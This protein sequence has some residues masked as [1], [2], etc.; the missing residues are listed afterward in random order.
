[1]KITKKEIDE[2][3]SSLLKKFSVYELSEDYIT[4]LVIS[5]INQKKNIDGNIID[6]SDFKNDLN[7]RFYISFKIQKYLYYSLVLKARDDV[8]V[9][10]QIVE[11]KRRIASLVLKKLKCDSNK[12]E[13]LIMDSLEFYDGSVTFDLFL[14]EFIMAKIK[15]ISFEEKQKA[16]SLAGDKVEELKKDEK[17]VINLVSSENKLTENISLESEEALET[18][19]LEDIIKETLYDK[20]K[21]KCENIKGTALID[22][23]IKFVLM[24]DLINIID[25]Y[26]QEFKVYF[27]MRF[28][29]MN[30]YFYTRD[31]IAAIAE[32]DIL[33]IIDYER[34]VINRIREFMNNSFINY[35]DYIIK[36]KI[37][38]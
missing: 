11:D 29:L 26:S 3:I 28:G 35:E 20:C 18:D 36:R 27:M 4:N 14:T 8:D 16:S 24:S 5:L 38:I 25:C 13:D 6:I 1:M 22:E 9:L 31:E 15:G 2:V 34:E 19:V 30:E 12:S 32:I 37:N 33:A 7:P 23:F 17:P 21:N 10:I